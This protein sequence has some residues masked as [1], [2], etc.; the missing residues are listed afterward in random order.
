[1]KKITFAALLVVAPLSFAA[2]AQDT[3]AV[4]SLADVMGGMSDAEVSTMENDT[5]NAGSLSLDMDWTIEAAV[6][7]AIADGLITADQAEDAAATM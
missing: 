7:E 6:S 1:M 3:A 4:P 5:A 2:Q